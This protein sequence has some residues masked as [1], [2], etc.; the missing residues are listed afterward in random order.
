MFKGE[1]TNK[2]SSSIFAIFVVTSL[3]L[4]LV[5]KCKKEDGKFDFSSLGG[6][7]QVLY[8]F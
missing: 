8:L 4:L 7:M 2:K 5:Q 3:I 6:M 1:S